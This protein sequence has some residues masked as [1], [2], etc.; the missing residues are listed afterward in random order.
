MPLRDAARL[1]LRNQIGG[2]PVVD[3]HGRCVGVFSA[4]DF[5]RSEMG[6]DAASPVSSRLPITCV[7]QAKHT[8][9][10]SDGKE[11]TRCML[12]SDFGEC[13]IQRKQEGPDGTKMNICSQPNSIFV[14]WQMVDVEKLPGDAVSRFMTPDTVT[15]QPATSIRVLARMMMDIHIHRIIVVDKL[16]RPIGVVSTTDVLEALAYSDG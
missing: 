12:P 1:L 10:T 6:A 16:R 14:A 7:F 2:A 8:T 13:P 9:R 11:V 5:L 3:L 15:A 4:I